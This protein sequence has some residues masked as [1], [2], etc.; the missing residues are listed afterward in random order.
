MAKFWTL[1]AVMILLLNVSCAS[2]ETSRTLPSPATSFD[3]YPQEIEMVFVKGGCYQMGDFFNDT[4]P[5]DDPAESPVHEVCVD[6]FYIGKYE[7]T[8]AQWKAVMGYHTLKMDELSGGLNSPVGNVS[9]QE[10][11]DFISKLNSK[12]GGGN[13]R[14]P[15]EA[16]WEYASRSGGKKERFSGTSDVEELG[17]F[18]WYEENSGNKIHPVGT[19]KPNGLGIHDMSGNVWEM[20]SDVFSNDYY[21]VSPRDNPKGPDKPEAKDDEHTER[22]GC[23][24]GSYLNQRTARRTSFYEGWGPGS[25]RSWSTGFRVVRTP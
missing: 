22:G 9:W 23:A 19:R 8:Q 24:S 6:D 5:D 1:S 3:G 12:K 13:Y 4:G 25:N 20:T 15:T 2:L 16:E 18:A 7:I 14:L 17:D 10:V 21:A 11:H